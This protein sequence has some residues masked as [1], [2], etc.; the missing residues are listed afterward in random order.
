MTQSIEPMYR[1]L[2]VKANLSGDFTV[3]N[4]YMVDALKARDLWDD[5]MVDDLK[6]Y[7]GSVQE[8]DRIH[9]ISKTSTKPRLKWHPNGSS[10]APA[11]G[12][13]GSIWDNR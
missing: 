11:A 12:K 13:S 10:N 6:Y 5:Q 4:P 2:Y 3:L 7:D 9:K 1:N 8:I